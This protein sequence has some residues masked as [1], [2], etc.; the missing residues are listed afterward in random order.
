MLYLEHFN[1][2]VDYFSP[3]CLTTLARVHDFSMIKLQQLFSFYLFIFFLKIENKGAS[4]TA[5]HR[6]DELPGGLAS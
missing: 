3:R 1:K 5:V 2:E 6:I 4:K